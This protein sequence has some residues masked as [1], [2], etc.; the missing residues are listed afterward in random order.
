MT[1]VLLD[2]HILI[3]ALDRPERLDPIARQLLADPATDVHFS[4]AVIRPN[5]DGPTSV[6]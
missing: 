5:R 6:G 3:W 4:A 2:T 1:L